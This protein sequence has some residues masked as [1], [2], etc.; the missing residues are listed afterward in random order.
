M[1]YPV[2]FLT[3][4]I[5]Y[6]SRQPLHPSSPLQLILTDTTF[7]QRE[8]LHITIFDNIIELFEVVISAEYNDSTNQLTLGM[9][10]ALNDVEILRM[11][12]RKKIHTRNI[13]LGT[14]LRV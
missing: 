12:V 11:H 7:K 8:I 3:I 10:K 2:P 13:F 9:H 1:K 5:L 14:L 6:K 4:P